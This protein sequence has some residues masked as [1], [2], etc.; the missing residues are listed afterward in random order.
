MPGLLADYASCYYIDIILY[1]SVSGFLVLLTE[2]SLFGGLRVGAHERDETRFCT[3]WLAL[4]SE[5]W[6]KS[7]L[8]TALAQISSFPTAAERNELVK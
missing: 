2:G 5:F 6:I 3:N 8:V 7:V 4:I 1:P